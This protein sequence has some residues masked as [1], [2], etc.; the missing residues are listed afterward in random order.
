MRPPKD[1]RGQRIKAT[2][3]ELRSEPGE[4]VDF[5]SHGGTVDLEKSGKPVAC[6]VPPFSNEATV[7]MPDGSIRGEIPLTCRRNLGNGGYGA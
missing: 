4:F 5:V 2:M 3:M 7:I 6:I 1:F